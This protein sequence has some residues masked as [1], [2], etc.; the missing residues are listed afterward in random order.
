MIPILYEHSETAFATNGI[1]RL[2]DSASCLVTEVLNGLYECELKYPI[3]GRHFSDIIEGRIIYT[4]HDDTHGPQP[5]EIYKK[6]ATINGIVTFNARHISYRLCNIILEPFTAGSVGAVFTH[7]AAYTLNPNPFT[8]GTDISGTVDFKLETPGS[9]KS[10][11]GGIKGSIVDTYGG[12][13]EWDKWTVFLRQRRGRETSIELRYGKNITD[14]QYDADASVTYTAVVPYW[15]QGSASLKM[16]P[17]KIVYLND[18]SSYAGR[19]YALDLTS[20]FESEPSDQQLLDAAHEALARA[21]IPDQSI[22]VNFFE[23]WNSKE[24]ENYSQLQRVYLGDS[25]KIIYTDLG[26]NTTLRAVKVVYD[27]LLERYSSIELGE[28][29]PSFGS[30][31]A[32]SFRDAMEQYAPSKS[33]MQQAIEHATSLITGGTGGHVVIG[34]N[35]DG[36]PNELFFMDTDN[37]QTAVNVLRINYQGIGFSS[38][39]V[40]GPFTTAWTLDGVFVADF[41]AAGVINA[42]LMSAGIITDTSLKN[43]WDL[44][45]G[46][47]KFDELLIGPTFTPVTDQT[48]TDIDNDITDAGRTATNYLY[49]SAQTGLVVSQTGTASGDNAHPFITQIVDAGINFKKQSK[50]LA[51]MTGTSMIFFRGLSEKKGMEIDA[52]NLTFYKPDGT[53]EAAR[54]GT[55]GLEVLYGIIGGFEANSSAFQSLYTDSNGNEYN[56][57]IRKS[58]GALTKVFECNRKLTTDQTALETVYIRNDGKIF[59]RNSIDFDGGIG[60]YLKINNGGTSGTNSSSMSIGSVQTDNTGTRFQNVYATSSGDIARLTTYGQ[61]TN[62]LTLY[63]DSASSKRYKNHVSDMSLEYARQVLDIT[64]I[65]FKYKAGYLVDGDECID[66]EIPGFYAEDVE[67]HYPLGVYHNEDGTVENWK[68]DRI[69]PAML[70]VIQEQDKEIAALKREIEEI[71]KILGV[72]YGN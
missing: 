41:I 27:S 26:I 36:Q 17:Q 39:G 24:F 40:E 31:L 12:E 71:K 56:V 5:Y 10:V 59:S 23:L 46:E 32:E 29:A 35:S 61:F 14:I 28:P 52:S 3:S 49:Y 44:E 6:S 72:Q 47:I 43:S 22:R 37:V 30:V 15:Q 53:T 13:Y 68:P 51:S 57:I 19:A 67:E 60:H 21:L 16:L 64:P 69:I 33:F 63:K 45:T 54:L 11:L 18:D 2:V 4:T 7:I 65:I 25:V 62:F 48:F 8:F 42:S 20:K 70:K 9:V 58:G 1:C 38:T 50:L 55:D 66:K 34:L